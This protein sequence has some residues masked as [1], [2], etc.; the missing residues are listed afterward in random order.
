MFLQRHLFCDISSLKLYRRSWQPR[1]VVITREIISFSFAHDDVELDYI[2]LADIDFVKTMRDSSDG[3]LKP[4]PSRQPDAEQQALQIA[5]SRDG[6]KSAE[7]IT[8]M[9]R[10][11]DMNISSL[12]AY[13]FI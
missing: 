3:R 12:Y 5:T 13:I 6:Y 4:S 7:C 8:F 11:Q 2:P 10:Y 9:S 1:R